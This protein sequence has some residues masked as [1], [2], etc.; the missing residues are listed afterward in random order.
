LSGVGTALVLAQ[1]AVMIRIGVGERSICAFDGFFERYPSVMVGIR[2]VKLSASNP[3]L[4]G[5][6]GEGP[7]WD[8]H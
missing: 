2:Q 5:W 7:L 8:H 3:A 6:G 1:N 4:D